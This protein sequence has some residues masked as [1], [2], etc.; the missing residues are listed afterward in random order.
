MTLKAVLFYVIVAWAVYMLLFALPVFAWDQ[1]LNLKLGVA[2]VLCEGA[3]AGPVTEISYEVSHDWVAIEGG[4]QGWTGIIHDTQVETAWVGKNMGR[5]NNL[6]YFLTGKFY[7]KSLYAGGGIGYLDTYF[8][9]NHRLYLPGVNADVDDEMS[10]HAVAGW[11]FAKNWFL[12]YKHTWADLDI[13]SNMFPEGILE[14]HS[15]FDNYAVMLGRK[16][17]F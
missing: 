3:D 16:F 17:R 4:I 14:A 1:S 11:V 13:E 9:E 10:F 8:A 5:L 15:R 12:E 7:Y 2:D 6:T